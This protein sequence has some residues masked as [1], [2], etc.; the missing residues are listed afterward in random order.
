VTLVAFAGTVQ[1]DS[2]AEVKGEVQG[3]EPE[4]AAETV[5]GSAAQPLLAAVLFASATIDA[6]Q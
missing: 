1:V 6:T 5:M 3:P 2:P 4:L